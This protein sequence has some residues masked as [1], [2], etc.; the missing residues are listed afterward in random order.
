M[1]TVK[2]LSLGVH[3]DYEG[4]DHYRNSVILDIIYCIK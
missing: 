2:L 1:E 3:S 4:S